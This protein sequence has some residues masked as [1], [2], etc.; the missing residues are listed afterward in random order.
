M[1]IPDFL[2]MASLAL[3]ISEK[4]LQEMSSAEQLTSTMFMR[5]CLD[6]WSKCRV[7]LLRFVRQQDDTEFRVEATLDLIRYFMPKEF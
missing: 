6:P 3:G 2:T 1:R 4:D 7:R 5:D